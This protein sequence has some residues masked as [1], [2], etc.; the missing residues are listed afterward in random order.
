MAWTRP[1]KDVAMKSRRKRDVLMMATRGN[2]RS[3]RVFSIKV[4][5]L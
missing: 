5:T 1:V 4:F 3:R 2:E